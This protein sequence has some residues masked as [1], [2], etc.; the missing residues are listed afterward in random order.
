MHCKVSLCYLN[1]ISYMLS[2]DIEVYLKIANVLYKQN[3]FVIYH[4]LQIEHA[5]NISYNSLID[6]SIYQICTYITYDKS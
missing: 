5:V 3:D 4:K 2:F 6:F 1:S